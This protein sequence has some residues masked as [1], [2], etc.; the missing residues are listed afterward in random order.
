MTEKD[1]ILTNEGLDIFLAKNSF[2]G[3]LSLYTYWLAYTSRKGFSFETKIG[4]SLSAIS[5][6]CS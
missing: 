5:S 4:A 3:L 1:M 2:S 6:S